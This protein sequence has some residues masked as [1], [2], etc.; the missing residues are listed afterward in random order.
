MNWME[1][2]LELTSDAS[3][4]RHLRT[5]SSCPWK[6]RLYIARGKKCCSTCPPMT[7]WDSLSILL[8]LKRCAIRSSSKEQA[9]VLPACDGQPCR[10]MI[11]LEK[12]LADW[13]NCDAA[14]V[15]A[16][17]Y[18]ANIWCHWRACGPGRCCFQ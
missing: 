9:P 11:D 12:A 7:I 14:L 15:F 18:M 2:E 13:Q 4:E 3:L 16:N 10:L 17:G 5:S 1:K 8:L 6:R